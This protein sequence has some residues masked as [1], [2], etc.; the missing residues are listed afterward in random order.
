MSYV[1]TNN[2]SIQID[3]LTRTYTVKYVIK[4]TQRI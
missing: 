2:R 3:V 1:H 4:G